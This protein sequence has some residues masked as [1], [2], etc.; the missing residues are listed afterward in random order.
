MNNNL[1][2][3]RITKVDAETG[4]VSGVLAEERPDRSGEVFDYKSSK[5]YFEKWVEHFE[6]AT[7]GASK[8][9]LRAMH[10]NVAAGK[11]VEV[12]F[13]D[14]AKVINVTAKVVDPVELDKV[15]E[16]VYTG[17]SI[18]GKVVGKRT[19]E[20]DVYRYTADPVEGSLVDLPCMHGATFKR[21]DADGETEV[22]FKGAG[23]PSAS[24][25][26][27]LIGAGL[28]KLERGEAGFEAVL[29][30]GAVD[31]AAMAA[32]AMQAIRGT[33]A[34]LT[35]LDLE[36]E[37]PL[38]DLV[39]ALRRMRWVKQ[40]ADVLAAEELAAG[41]EVP[42][43][44]DPTPVAAEPEPDPELEGDEM[45]EADDEIA[46]AV[47]AL[48]EKHGA[49]AQ[50]RLLTAEGAPAGVLVV[51]LA[52]ADVDLSKLEELE[53]V[54]AQLELVD[55]DGLVE[56]IADK[57]VERGVVTSEALDEVAK[58]T[59]DSLDAI[60]TQLAKALGAP[61]PA[62]RPVRKRLGGGELDAGQGPDEGRAAIEKAGQAIA[63]R[64]DLTPEQKRELGLELATALQG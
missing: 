33:L 13:D 29:E 26:H 23:D 21:C 31:A 5:P 34:E 54:P 61:A 64:A 53:Q 14:T 16:G 24:I 11:F 6:Q 10:G 41:A 49:E 12:D 25:V 43:P 3:A 35:G 59:A 27:Q 39:A 57:L 42:E 46:Q 19:R 40:L 22:V 28:A 18:G 55:D 58:A 51:R 62:G 45:L 1:A 37:W 48:L 2:F 20:G 9:N 56:K 15:L 8:G 47:Q 36:D 63:N 32:T 44:A 7:G 30:K 4:L 38:D 60:A 50:V 52:D 17:F